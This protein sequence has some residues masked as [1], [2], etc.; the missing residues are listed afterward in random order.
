MNRTKAALSSWEINVA[1][2]LSSKDTVHV[3]EEH[4]S[5][6]DAFLNAYFLFDEIHIPSEYKTSKFLS[7]LDSSKKIFFPDPF[8]SSQLKKEKNANPY[9]EIDPSLLYKNKSNLIEKEQ[10]W[11]QQHIV[12][13]LSKKERTVIAEEAERPFFY[14]YLLHEYKILQDIALNNDAFSMLCASLSQVFPTNLLEIPQFVKFLLST[15]RPDQEQQSSVGLG[16]YLFE[17]FIGEVFTK[18]RIPFFLDI[19]LEEVKS[20]TFLE[21]LTNLRE[22]FTHFRA[23]FRDICEAIKSQETKCSTPKKIS[24]NRVLQWHKFLE[25]NLN[26][27]ATVQAGLFRRSIVAVHVQEIMKNDDFIKTLKEHTRGSWDQLKFIPSTAFTF[28]SKVPAK[29]AALGISSVLPLD[30]GLLRMHR[31]YRNL[32]T[33]INPGVCTTVVSLISSAAQLTQQELDDPVVIE[34]CEKNP[35]HLYAICLRPKITVSP[36]ITFS[37]NAVS[38]YLSF[39]DQRQSKREHDLD[40]QK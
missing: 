13:D 11:L 20:R 18:I 40:T 14:A 37:K 16:T 25:E 1:E 8:I 24:E 39:S 12:H 9:L 33:V 10:E 23:K 26:G 7:S 17:S 27:D 29:L 21:A 6:L 32:S 28:F 19:F 22:K 30:K 34:F 35:S 36:D 38:G 2:M 15:Q 4:L 31:E 3:T 5:R